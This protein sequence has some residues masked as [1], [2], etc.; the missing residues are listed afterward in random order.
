MADLLDL[1]GMQAL[2]HQANEETYLIEAEGL[3]VP[4]VNHYD[5]PVSNAH[6][7]SINNIAKQQNR[8]G[9]GYSF[10]VIR[11]RLLYDK[12][13]RA[14]STT[15]MRSRSRKR[16][17]KDDLTEHFVTTQEIFE[18][19]E[20]KPRVIEYGPHLPTLAK[21]LEEAYFE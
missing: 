2:S 1:P 5:H 18:T 9:R 11:A 3:I 15:V 21:L 14:V 10:E 8:M 16:G 13:A 19:F 17:T 4:T 6:T 12:K 7:E 20:Q